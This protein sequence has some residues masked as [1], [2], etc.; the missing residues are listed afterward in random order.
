M[1]RYKVEIKGKE[2]VVYINEM[3]ESRFRVVL[4]DKVTEVQLLSD[5]DLPESLITPGIIPLR[6]RDEETIERPV[7]SY[8]PPSAEA[9]GPTPESPSPTLPPKPFLPSD[10]LREDITSPMPGVIQE[11]HVKPGDRV[12]HGQALLVL[13]AM[14]MKNSIKSPRDG[15]IASVAVQ[16]GQC[17]NYG[18]VLIKFEQ[19]E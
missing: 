11:I 18:D 19:E 12:K 13:E 15:I 5:Q 4:D 10:G 6:T 17:V 2:Y 7:A 1:R 9:F 3:S 14:K 16:S 8:S